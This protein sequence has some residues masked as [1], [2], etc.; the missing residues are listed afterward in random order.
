MRESG[1]L[2]SGVLWQNRKKF[3]ESLRESHVKDVEHSQ[4]ALKSDT[5]TRWRTRR[6]R[7]SGSASRSCTMRCAHWE[8]KDAYIER[9]STKWEL[10]KSRRTPVKTRRRR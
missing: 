4:K 9:D 7:S 5:L 6:R 10:F 1:E 3:M 8:G 2:A